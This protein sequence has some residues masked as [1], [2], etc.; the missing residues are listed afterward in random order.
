MSDH[1]C[2]LTV[3]F[4]TD[5]HQDESERIIDAIMQLRHV[6]SVVPVV[7]TSEYHCAKQNAS[8]D[9]KTKLYQFLKDN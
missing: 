6:Q 2:A 5:V 7:A 9:W 3:V 8:W 4:D 1:H